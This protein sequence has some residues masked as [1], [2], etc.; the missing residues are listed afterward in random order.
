MPSVGAHAGPPPPAAALAACMQLAAS[1]QRSPPLPLC[2]PTQAPWISLDKELRP[3]IELLHGV[4]GVNPLRTL[5]H[6]PTTL[7]LLLGPQGA[8]ARCVPRAPAR[9]GGGNGGVW[10]RGRW[11]RCPARAPPPPPPPPPNTH[12]LSTLQSR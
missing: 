4:R 7:A 3:T 11:W 12:T 2:P 8:R 1:R 5:S 6:D 9:A 10:K